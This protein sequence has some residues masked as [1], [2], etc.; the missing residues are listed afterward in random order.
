MK[1]KNSKEFE[2]KADE[3]EWNDHSPL[4]W[5]STKKEPQKGSVLLRLIS[6]LILASAEKVKVSRKAAAHW[7]GWALLEVLLF[8]TKPSAGEFSVEIASAYKCQMWSLSKWASAA[9]SLA[10]LSSIQLTITFCA[11]AEVVA[12]AAVPVARATATSTNLC[13]VTRRHLKAVMTWLAPSQSS[14]FDTTVEGEG[15]YLNLYWCL[16]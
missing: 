8:E 15:H 13:I 10:T 7:C 12:A 1:I 2:Q 14:I 6:P 3:G 16:D 4:V 5:S 9:I 11:T